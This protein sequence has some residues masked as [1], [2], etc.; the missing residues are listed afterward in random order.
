MPKY[1][2][3]DDFLQTQ[4]NDI[5]Q[6][7]EEFIDHMLKKMDEHIAKNGKILILSLTK[8]SSEEITNFLLSKGYKAYYL[9]SEID[10]MERRETINKLKTGVIDI[11][12]GVNLLRE[13]IDLPEVS[14]IVILDADKEGFLRS[15]TALIQIIGRAARNVQ[16][17]V[18]LY[19]DNF[20]EAMLKSL[21]ETYRRRSIQQKYNQDHGI[22]PQQ[23]ISNAKSIQSVKSWEDTEE[24]QFFHLNKGK[25]KK[26]KRATKAEKA[27][28]SKN[29]K[30]QLDEAIHAW[31]FEKA[32]VIRDQIKEI[33]ES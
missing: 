20:T 11:I 12:V 7:T 22:I 9:H 21:R 14:L 16:S 33:E 28:I 32:A 24:Q 26:L 6:P 29:L 18:V 5:T 8:K 31:D 30:K 1:S 25:N 10:T 23:V 2:N 4:K 15:N 17:E 27:I 3:L 13:G 19:A